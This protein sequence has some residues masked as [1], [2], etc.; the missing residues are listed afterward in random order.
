MFLSNDHVGHNYNPTL[1]AF[2]PVDLTH[3]VHGTQSDGQSGVNTVNL[4][5]YR[6]FK[7]QAMSVRGYL[8][9]D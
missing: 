5:E 4:T 8:R 6:L 7:I 3:I 9:L 2:F 1:H